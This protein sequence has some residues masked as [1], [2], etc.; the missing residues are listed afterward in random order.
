MQETFCYFVGILV[1]IWVTLLV[2]FPE[3]L[4]PELGGRKKKFKGRHWGSYGD[5]PQRAEEDKEDEEC[6]EV[7]VPAKKLIY[8]VGSGTYAAGRGVKM[9]GRG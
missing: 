4:V 7:G 3:R 6:I 5:A 9:S 2:A 8:T 1:A